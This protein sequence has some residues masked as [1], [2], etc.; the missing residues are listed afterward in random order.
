MAEDGGG[1]NGPTL[2]RLLAKGERC[3]RKKQ[4]SV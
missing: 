4:N 1:G 3:S 2:R